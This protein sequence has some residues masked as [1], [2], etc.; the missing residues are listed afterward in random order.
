M[1][2]ANSQ[3]K[4]VPSNKLFYRTTNQA[5]GSFPDYSRTLN[6]LYRGNPQNTLPPPPSPSRFSATFS[7]SSSSSD[8]KRL[9]TPKRAPSISS[10]S[11]SMSFSSNNNNN[12]NNN[13]NNSMDNESTNNNSVRFV[14][15]YDDNNNN[16]DNYNKYN[17]N[18]YNNNNTTQSL[19]L[20]SSSSSSVSSSC[21]HDWSRTNSPLSK[22]Q[23]GTQLPS[24]SWNTPADFICQEDLIAKREQ[25]IRS[26][27]PGYTG[28]I[29]G[30]AFTIGESYGKT[31][32]RLAHRRQAEKV[33]DPRLLVPQYVR[34]KLW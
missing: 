26:H 27:L 32:A 4:R 25:G 9:S 10:S 34:L 16:N 13:N 2:S 28:Y 8:S 6:L 18:K 3:T 11:S 5:Y 20:S 15:N 30:S 23:T 24:S 29:S 17:N 14:D 22:S 7:S 12:Y 31:S 19:S 21:T 33:D 1:T